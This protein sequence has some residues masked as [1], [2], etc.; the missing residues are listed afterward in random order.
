LGDQTF[1]DKENLIVTLNFKVVSD[2]DFT[3]VSMISQNDPSLAGLFVI[4]EC[5][6]LGSSVPGSSVV[7]QK[8]NAT[9][10]GQN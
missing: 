3:I 7:G 5:D 8:T 10:L 2:F 4:D 6:I 9:I 1:I